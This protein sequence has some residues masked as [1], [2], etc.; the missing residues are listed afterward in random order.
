MARPTTGVFIVW[1]QEEVDVERLDAGTV[2]DRVVVTGRRVV[3]KMA[4]YT[5]AVNPR[6]VERAEQYVA[7][8]KGDD[9]YPN[10]RVEVYTAKNR[11][12]SSGADSPLTRS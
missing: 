5:L 11:R 3:P 8:L 4:L 12:P 10:V 7:S 2:R 6:N 9:Y 1:D